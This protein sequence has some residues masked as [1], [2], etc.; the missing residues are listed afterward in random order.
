[1]KEKEE[2]RNWAELDEDILG[3]V[4][5]RR[6]PRQDYFRFGAVCRPWSEVQRKV[7]PPP[8]GPLPWILLDVSSSSSSDGDGNDNSSTSTYIF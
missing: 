8:I 1:M 5:L 3:Q 6:L 7:P 2:G 4:I